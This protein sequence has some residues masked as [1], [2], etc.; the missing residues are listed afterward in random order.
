[1]TDTAT[2][3]SAA[4]AFAIDGRTVPELGRDLL[5]LDIEE[6]RLGL[7]TM[8]ARLSAVGPQSDGSVESL[9]Y[10]DGELVDLGS[11]ITAT[12]GA[13]AEIRQ[14]FAGSVS[15]LEI[16]FEEGGYPVV[17]VFAEDALMHLRMTSR[18]ATHREATDGDILRA[19]AAE[20]GLGAR[21]DI[22]EQTYPV[23]QQMAESDLAFLRRRARRI[24]AELWV[25]ADEVLHLADRRHREGPRLDLVQGNDLITVSARADLAHQRSAVAVRG[26]DRRRVEVVD[27]RAG[28]DAVAAEAVG[29]RT[30]PRVVSQVFGETALARA[31]RE[32][33]DASQA[34]AYAQAEMLRRARGFVAVDGTTVGTPDLVP[35]AHLTLHRVGRPFE[36]GGYRAVHVHHSY[37]LTV[38]YRTGFHAERPEVG[39]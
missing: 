32:A 26:W 9:L 3:A 19:I 38:G 29:D 30:G 21:V 23:I 24:N 39:S 12:L 13:P 2:Y 6:G 14:V 11:P 17:S 10:L 27:E 8:V 1:M 31:E 4:P 36:G 34:R 20:H 22:D 28:A 37:D 5:R 16:T 18:S 25:D 35:G 33:A 15:A 7:R